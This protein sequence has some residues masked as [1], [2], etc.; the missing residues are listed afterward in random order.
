[1]LVPRAISR[2]VYSSFLLAHR[3]IDPY[4]FDKPLQLICRSSCARHWFAF[5]VYIPNDLLRKCM[6]RFPFGKRC[7]KNGNGRLSCL[8]GIFQSRDSIK[9]TICFFFSLHFDEFRVIVGIVECWIRKAQ[10]HTVHVL[11]QSKVWNDKGLW[12]IFAD[13]ILLAQNN[14]DDNQWVISMIVAWE[15]YRATLY[16]IHDVTARAGT[17]SVTRTVPFTEAPSSFPDSQLLSCT[18][19]KKTKQSDSFALFHLRVFIMNWIQAKH[20]WYIMLRPRVKQVWRNQPFAPRDH[21]F[22]DRAYSPIHLGNIC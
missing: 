11:V 22:I 17:T 18:T 5:S 10:F 19:E 20:A 16:L 7:R 2:N 14:F 1:M 8:E 21:R 13:F 4:I 15:Q 3:S 9:K 6:D 12:V